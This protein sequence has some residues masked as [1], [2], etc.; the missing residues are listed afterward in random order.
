MSHKHIINMLLDRVRSFGFFSFGFASA[1][2][3][4]VMLTFALAIVP[5][6]GLSGAAI[7]YSRANSAK[8]AMQSAADATSLMLAKDVQKLTSA[9]ISQKA[10]EY[11][12]ALFTRPET[13]NISI[14]P[15]FTKL[16]AG[17]FKLQ[18]A[19]SG[20]VPSTL[21][22]VFGPPSLNVNVNSEVIWGIRKLELALA[23]DNTG[24]MSSNNKMTNLK[25]AVH[26]L[27]TTL[28]DAA[29]TA[30]DVKVA[31]IPFDTTV[32]L[33][34]NYKDNKWFDYSNLSCG[35]NT[36]TSSNWKNYWEGCVRDRTYPYD[37]QDDPPA[38]INT[39]Y[40]VYDCGSLTTLMPLGYDWAA[41]NNKVDAMKPNGNTD[42]TIGLVWAWHALTAQAPLSEAVPPTPDLD[43]VI[44][45]LTDGDNTEAWKNSE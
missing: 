28:K 23:L 9:Q 17:S 20:S 12:N 11:F 13:T 43:K 6:V 42:V 25:T 8:A 33:G 4:N 19:V 35:T 14:T 21:T 29:K 36:C 39:Y 32:N 27:L 16:E 7:D 31:I 10:N 26:N 45:L 2:G 30:G 22:K 18:L 38:S 5:I 24:S 37:V 34:T 40:P 15:T 44:I 1:T 41:L 3:G